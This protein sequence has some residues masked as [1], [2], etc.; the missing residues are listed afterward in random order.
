MSEQLESLFPNLK[1]SYYKITSPQT[2]E[3]NCIAWAAEDE[4]AWWWPDPDNIYYWPEEVERK[5]T[6]E[7]FKK[8]FQTL[9][10]QECDSIIS[11]K[12]YEKIAIFADNQKFPTHASRQLRT[13]YWTSKLG[14]LEDIEHE[15]EGVS[16]EEYGRIAVVMKRP[17]AI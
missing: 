12:G 8:A 6:L 7:A 10:Y 17:H 16:G 15:T 3:Y 9:G 14:N 5:E 4:Q 11:E 13:G 2:P 1:N